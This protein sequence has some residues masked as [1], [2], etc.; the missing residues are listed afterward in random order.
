M[1]KNSTNMF[2]LGI[3]LCLVCA[4]AAVVMGT[5]AVVTKEPIE[6][7]KVKKVADGLRVVLPPFNNDPMTDVKKIMLIRKR[8]DDGITVFHIAKL[9]GK[10]VGYAAKIAVHS[11]Y[12][13]TIEALV[14]FHPDGSIRTILV[15]GHGETPGLGSNAVERSA[16]RTLADVLKGKKAP[17]GLPPNKILDQYSGHSAAATDPW[18]KPW[19][20]KKDGGEAEYVSGATISSRAVNDLAWKAAQAFEA[21]RR[22]L[23]G[24]TA[25]TE[26]A[27]N[28]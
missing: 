4:F 13:G 27:K 2:Y 18:K 11:G 1:S 10:T 12:G 26:G 8:K 20:V 5:A 28:Q 22:E 6:K 16:E 21:L 15:T 17:A 7:T 25:G 19:K 23:A 9:N 24:G 3:F 14:S